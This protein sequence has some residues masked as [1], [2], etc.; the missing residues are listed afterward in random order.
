MPAIDTAII[1]GLTFLLAGLVKG[2]IGLGVPTVS[3]AILTATLGLKPAMALLLFPSFVTNLWQ[4]LVGGALVDILKRLWLL[5]AMVCVGTW[6]G[7]SVLAAADAR[8]MSAVLGGVLAV[9]AGVN[10]LRAQVPSP[11]KAEVFVSPVI[12][13]VNGVLT[14]MTGSFVVPGVPYLQALG[15]PRDVLVQAM[16]VLFTVSTV[17]LALSLGDQRLLSMELGLTSLAAVIPALI[18][19]VAGQRV[20]KRL[21][22]AAF[23]KVFFCALL[24]LGIYIAGRALI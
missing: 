13:A 9:Y 2:V 1:I 4:G 6:F 21:S 5:L 14:G 24:V 22:E 15:L 7:V 19:M 17:A 3:L 23:R 16:G 8:T 10:L 11:G 12:G 20:R 18:G